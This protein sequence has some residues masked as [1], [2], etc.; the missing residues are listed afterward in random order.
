V[1]ALVMLHRA[2]VASIRHQMT[3]LTAALQES[4]ADLGDDDEHKL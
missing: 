1:R 3:K 4:L 2:D